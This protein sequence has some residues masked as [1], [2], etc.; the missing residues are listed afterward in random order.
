MRRSG[1]YDDEIRNRTR[2]NSA[3]A[4][5]TTAG[6][7]ERHS[8]QFAAVRFPL[9]RLFVTPG[10]MALLAERCGTGGLH[11]VQVTAR[12]EDPLT[13]VLLYVQR[14]ASGDWGDVGAE[15]WNANDEAL[16]LGA[17]LF[18][19]YQQ[20]SCRPSTNAS[21]WTSS[22]NS[23]AL[24]RVASARFQLLSGVGLQRLA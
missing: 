12:S 7:G 22:E 24:A 8:F 14:H 2:H 18:S 9:G 1:F 4:R 10:A 21:G 19:A 5:R 16:T 13:L 6:K 15:D 23:T 20:S 3:R 11:S 17:R